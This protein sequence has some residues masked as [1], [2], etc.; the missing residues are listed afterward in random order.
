[1]VSLEPAAAGSDV[2]YTPLLRWLPCSS[3]D[4]ALG[5]TSAVSVSYGVLLGR[6]LANPSYGLSNIARCSASVSVGYPD[7]I[8]AACSGLLRR[9][10][11]SARSA[12]AALTEPP[13]TSDELRL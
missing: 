12:S 1:M 4:L 10:A 6:L 5:R 3:F 9:N 11:A 8:H 13:R 7:S 2:G